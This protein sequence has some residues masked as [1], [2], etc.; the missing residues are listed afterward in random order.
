MWLLSLTFFPRVFFSFAKGPH[1][2]KSKN[3]ILFIFNN[4]VLF[5]FILHYYCPHPILKRLIRR[6]FYKTLCVDHS[7]N[8]KTVS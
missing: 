2:E 7:C 3:F 4:S 5:C 8:I 6:N 1:S